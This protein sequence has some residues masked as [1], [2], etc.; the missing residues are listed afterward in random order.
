LEFWNSLGVKGFELG[1][2]QGYNHEKHVSSTGGVRI[3]NGIAHCDCV[4]AYQRKNLT[5][6]I[7]SPTT[8]NAVLFYKKPFY[9][10][11]LIII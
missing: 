5:E 3:L 11:A 8:T 7:H 6:F 1:I 10:S 4:A 2:L 9:V